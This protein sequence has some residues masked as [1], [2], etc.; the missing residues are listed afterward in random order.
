M[1][2][3]TVDGSLRN[4]HA[5]TRVNHGV[6][7][8]APGPRFDLI[9]V[10]RE[11]IRVPVDRARNARHVPE[12]VA[13]VALEDGREDALG[14][15]LAETVLG[16]RIAHGTLDLLRREDREQLPRGRVAD[17][18]AERVDLRVTRRIEERGDIDEHALVLDAGDTALG[19]LA[20]DVFDRIGDGAH[21]P[22]GR[23]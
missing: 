1:S 18:A 20:H 15:H 2:V 22:I 14:V 10:Q 6:L 3:G 4:L 23:R 19:Q 13:L 12:T 17:G 8:V 11:H 9:R 21:E 16:L 5:R 7:R